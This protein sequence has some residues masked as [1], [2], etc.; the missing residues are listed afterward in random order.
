MNEVTWECPMCGCENVK[1][2]DFNHISFV[3]T[4]TIENATCNDCENISELSIELQPVV[5][6]VDVKE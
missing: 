6:W 1:S 2:I 3:E 5:T 4:G